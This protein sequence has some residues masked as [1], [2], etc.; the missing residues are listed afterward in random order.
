[1]LFFTTDEE[2]EHGFDG[3][4]RESGFPARGGV[5]PS[6]QPNATVAEASGLW[7]PSQTLYLP[8]MKRMNTHET[9][10]LWNQSFKHSPIPS[11]MRV[12]KICEIA[13]GALRPN[14]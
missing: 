6:A 9:D 5:F 4:F 7:P 3:F 1:V 11:I 10:F 14:R 12:I 13:G 8:H 2:D